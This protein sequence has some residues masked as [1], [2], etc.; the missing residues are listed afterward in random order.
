MYFNAQTIIYFDGQYAWATDAHTNLYSQTLHYGY[1][2]F[3]GIRSYRNERS[4]AQ[5]FKPEAHFLR[6]KNSCELLGIPLDYS[7]EQMTEI[8]YNVLQRNGLQDAYLRPLVICA[9]NMALINGQPSRLLVAAWSWGAYLGEK[10]LRLKISPYCRP[11]PRSTHIEAKAVGHYVNSILATSDA[12]RDGFDEALLLDCEGYLAE[13]PGANFF[14][15]KDGVLFTPATGHILPG[16][17]RQTVLECSATLGIPVREGQFTLEDLRQAD[18]AFFC[19]TGA[20]IIGI[21]S[22]DDI[23]FPK[24]WTETLGAQL[25]QEYLTLV[26]QPATA[27]TPT[28]FTAETTLA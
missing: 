19:G 1:G 18:S 28:S 12:K 4:E 13:G 16:I 3:E 2:V 8:S 10:L 11:H 9:P 21:Q 25:R 15:E 20:E 27:T 7:V 26:R 17:T 5:I 22:V 6:L 14:F 24:P 23:V